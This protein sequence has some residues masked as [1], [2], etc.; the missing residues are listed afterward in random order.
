[1]RIFII[2][3]LS[4]AFLGAC[5]SKK[6]VV[7]EK[8]VD[9]I[10]LKTDTL[11][12]L[13]GDAINRKSWKHFSSRMGIDYIAGDGQE[14]SGT[15]SVRMRN[16]SIIWFSV[17]VA[18]GIQVAKG[19]ITHDSLLML[20][21]YHKEYVRASIKDLSTM[22]GANVSLRQLQNI[23]L[24]NPV[25]DTL[26]YQKDSQSGGWFVQQPP[27]ANLLFT[28]RSGNIDSSVVAESGQLRQLKSVY[29]GEMSA[30]SYSIPEQMRL[31]AF[32]DK[33][34]VRLFVTFTNPSDA[35]IP[36]YPFSIPAGYTRKE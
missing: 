7:A 31:T 36:S 4:L 8:R 3:I 9:I 10:T 18:M 19:I 33:N 26:Y 15:I 1:L 22:L 24:A 17:S 25:F 16:D 2:A 28:G 20:D 21:L 32:G 6:N 13:K 29:E 12:V 14:M 11:L 5:K 30:G 23:I 34:T 35:V 27:L